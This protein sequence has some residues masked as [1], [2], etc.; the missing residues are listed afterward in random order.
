MQTGGIWNDSGL[1]Y[2]SFAEQWDGGTAVEGNGETDLSASGEVPGDVRLIGC[3]D[4]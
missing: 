4:V 3:G 2:S 1:F